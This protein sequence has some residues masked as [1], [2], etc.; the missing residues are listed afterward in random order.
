MEELNFISFLQMKR[1]VRDKKP[2]C[3]WSIRNFGNPYEIYLDDGNQSYFT[4]HLDENKYSKEDIEEIADE[5]AL[6]LG[7]ECEITELK[8]YK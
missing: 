1:M 2:S 8:K 3:K 5:L 4:F 7:I 6:F